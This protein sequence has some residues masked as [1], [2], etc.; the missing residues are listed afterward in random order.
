ML[1]DICIRTA[2]YKEMQL[3]CPPQLR[4]E[5][6]AV[7]TCDFPSTVQSPGALVEGEGPGPDFDAAPL[8]GAL[9]QLQGSL[10]QLSPH[11]G[12]EESECKEV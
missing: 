9:R 1:K 3:Q 4:P 5:K 10:E 12:A 7:H 2:F 6:A 8:A 11:R